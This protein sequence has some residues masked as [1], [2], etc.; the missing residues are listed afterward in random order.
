MFRRCM[1]W[2]T[3]CGRKRRRGALGGG[4]R[5]MMEGRRTREVWENVVG[6]MEVFGCARV[7][8]VLFDRR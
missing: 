4:V 7:G 8:Y 1:W 5:M 6:E 3:G 2:I